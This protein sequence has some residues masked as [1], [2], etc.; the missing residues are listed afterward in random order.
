MAILNVHH[1]TC[2]RYSQPVEFGEHRFMSRPRDSHD[3]RLI[4]TTH[5][6]RPGAERA[7][8]DPR[9]FRQF[10]RHCELRC[11]LRTRSRSNPRFAR[12]HYPSSRRP[13]WWSPTPRAFHSVTPPTTH[14]IWDGRRSGIYL[15]PEHRIDQWAKNVLDAHA[16][17]Q[18]FRD[19]G[20]HDVRD[21]RAISVCGA[22][23]RRRAVAAGDARTPQRQLSGFCGFHDGGGARPRPRGALRV[24]LP[25]R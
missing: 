17:R 10:H 16:R 23:A 13:S 5:P 11:A 15:D 19:A 2:Y 12:K 6:H 22:R 3:L 14:W 24:G 4:D 25:L 1:R 21:Q 9:C 8:L 7:A 20:G 18:H